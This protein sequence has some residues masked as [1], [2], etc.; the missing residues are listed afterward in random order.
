MSSSS[1]SCNDYPRNMTWE[2]D[3]P[4]PLSIPVPS[5]MSFH[6]VQFSAQREGH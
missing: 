6:T 3:P 1:L 5:P 2:Y 4:S